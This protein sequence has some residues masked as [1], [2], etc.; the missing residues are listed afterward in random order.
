MTQSTPPRPEGS[1]PPRGAPPSGSSK[2]KRKTIAVIGAVA[3]LA[4]VGLLFWGGPKPPPE[5]PPEPSPAQSAAAQ[6]GKPR[7]T[8]RANNAPEPPPPPEEPPLTHEE[9]RRQRLQRS[10]ETYLEYAKYP[11]ASRPMRE[12]PDQGKPHFVPPNKLPLARADGKLTDAMV[13]LSQD[14]YY[15][16]GDE[17]AAFT[18]SCETSDGPAAC[19]VLSSVTEIPS[20]APARVDGVSEVPPPAPV[21]FNDAGQNGDMAA[22]DG[23]HTALFAPSAQ[24]FQ[25]YYGPIQIDIELRVEGETGRASFDVMYTP[26]APAVFTGKVREAIEDGSLSLYAEMQVDKPGR[27][28]IAAR[29]DDDTGK[30]FAYLNFNEEV[31]AGRQEAKLVVF[32]RLIRDEQAKPP[33]RLRDLEGFLL[34]ENTSPDRELMRTLEGVVHSTR[35]YSVADFSERE[36]ESEEKERHVKEYERILEQANAGGR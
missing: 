28:V 32:G 24:G 12:H 27:Y 22:G 1:A 31:K 11:P 8:P 30:S 29:V 5:P 15:L 35:P 20:H 25:S 2:P 36:W 19:E 17:R 26:K 13:T 23:T 6:A 9:R 7:A 16:V 14:R 3:A 4:A 10:L 21:P 34:K 18:I 33:F